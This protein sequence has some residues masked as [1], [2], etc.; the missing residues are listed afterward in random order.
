MHKDITLTL[1]MRS[2]VNRVVR[3]TLL[4]HIVVFRN[5]YI[6]CKNTFLSTY[7]SHADG[8]WGSP[9]LGRA[10][11]VSLEE[12]PHSLHAGS[13]LARGTFRVVMRSTYS[14]GVELVWLTSMQ[15]AKIPKWRL[16]HLER[17]WFILKETAVISWPKMKLHV[18]KVVTLRQIIIVG[19]L[20]KCN[21]HTNMENSEEQNINLR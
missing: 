7:V 19:H 8:E 12:R 17:A 5:P 16:T 20:W 6:R 18:V 2:R 14:G 13:N 10:A 4:L 15:E 1:R 11:L 21:I 9:D 3:E